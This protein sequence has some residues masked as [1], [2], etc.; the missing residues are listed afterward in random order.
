MQWTVENA[1]ER[2]HKL[3]NEEFTRVLK[4]EVLLILKKQQGFLEA[5][6]FFP[7]IKNE[8]ALTVMLW[9]EK[10]DIERV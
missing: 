9:A 8:K 6:P 5:L 4:N 3:R 1:T 7:E 2:P 10:K